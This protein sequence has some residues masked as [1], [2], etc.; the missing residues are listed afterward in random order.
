MMIWILKR[1]IISFCSNKISCSHLNPRQLK[2]F[3]D[4]T[5]FWVAYRRSATFFRSFRL[6]TTSVGKYKVSPETGYGDL[7]STPAAE[8][9]W[10]HRKRWFF[11]FLVIFGQ[12]SWSSELF[13]SFLSVSTSEAKQEMSLE[14]AKSHLKPIPAAKVC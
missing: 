11:G 5:H 1:R 14:T 13:W 7:R 4:F 10:V 12:F 8:V 6:A 3:Q 9:C 2:I